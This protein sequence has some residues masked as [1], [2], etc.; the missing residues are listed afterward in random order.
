MGRPVVPSSHAHADI[1]SPLA[2]ASRPVCLLQAALREPVAGGKP[3]NIVQNLS[4]DLIDGG[5]EPHTTTPMTSVTGP[6]AST[7]TSN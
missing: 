2:W 6:A 7:S 1:D 4:G 5:A 3:M